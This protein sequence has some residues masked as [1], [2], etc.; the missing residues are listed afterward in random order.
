[1]KQIWDRRLENKKSSIWII[2]N[3]RILRAQ[4]R[5]KWVNAV[6]FD[7]VYAVKRTESNQWSIPSASQQ[8]WNHT[9]DC[10]F[11]RSSP[12]YI[13]F[14][15]HYLLPPLEQHI[16]NSDIWQS[17]IMKN[18]KGNQTKALNY[19]LEDLPRRLLKVRAVYARRWPL[20]TFWTL[21]KALLNALIGW[22]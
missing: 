20:R 15:K 8:S 10:F 9:V 19:P 5:K 21:H 4:V 6:D 16:W 2:K 3:W 14:I 13:E 1:M 17:L 7:H 12:S 11:K 22:S 18:I